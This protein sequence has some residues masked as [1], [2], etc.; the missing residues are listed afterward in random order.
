MPTNVSLDHVAVASESWAEAW[1]RYVVELG[2]EWSS[3]GQ[4]VGFA[5]H[6]LRFANGARLEV[7]QPWEV[8]GNSF[9]RRF[10]DASGPGPHHLT[11]KVPDLAAALA[12]AKAAGL[13]PVGIDLSDPGWKEAF[14]HPREATGVVVQL[15]QAE[16]FW[17]SPQPEGFPTRRPPEPAALTHVVHVVADLDR[18]LQLFA[19]LLGGTELRRDDAPDGSWRSVTLSWGGPLSL[20]LVGPLPGGLPSGALVEWLDGRSGRIHHLAFSQVGT[21]TTPGA[22]LPGLTGDQVPCQVVTPEDNL[23]VRLVVARRG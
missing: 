6:Q 19:G 22:A 4:N 3:G 1:P 15:A 10:L 7:L 8:D 5:P 11:F 12:G 2:G 16:G 20:R 21:A 14:L 9:L 18:G 13:S 23:G 17:E